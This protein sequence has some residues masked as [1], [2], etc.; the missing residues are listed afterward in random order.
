MKNALVT[1]ATGF[2]GRHLVPSLRKSGMNVIICNQKTNNL[3]DLKMLKDNL[4]KIELNYIFHCAVKTH[5]GGYCQQHP[6]EQ[7]LLNQRMN[8]N[9]LEVWK[10]IQPQAKFITFGTSCGY[11]DNEIKVES[12]YMKGDPESGYRTYGYI[13]RMLLV[14][15]EA[16]AQE[17]DMKYVYFIPSTLYGEK[18][19]LDDKHFIFDL[20]RKISGAKESGRPPVL[21]G[22]GDQRRDLLY[23]RDAIRLI[24]STLNTNNQVINLCSGNNYSI[25]E[26]AQII[27]DIIDFDF[28][29][30]EFDKNAFVGAMSKNLVNT[31]YKDAEFTSINEGLK[32][33]IQYFN[34][35]D[36]Q[37]II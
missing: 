1:G 22:T 12:N 14:G 19:D 23:S 2:L 20:I 9:I 21:W 3:L 10:D 24:L 36:N 33:T 32:N 25:K 30:I 11:S 27:C 18:Y 16:L 35:R 37:G 28:N 6:G 29:K 8:N 17:F 15:L 13:K 26:Y 34:N 4:S 5:A 31:F 7:Y